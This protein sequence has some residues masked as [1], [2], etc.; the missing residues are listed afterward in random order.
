[1]N[2]ED[3]QWR[4]HKQILHAWFHTKFTANDEI[5]MKPTGTESAVFHYAN[6]IK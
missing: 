5:V 6:F 4:A 3:V 2:A 1:M